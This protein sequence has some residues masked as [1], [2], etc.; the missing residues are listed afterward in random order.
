MSVGASRGYVRYVQEKTAAAATSA[1]STAIQPLVE[2]QDMTEAAIIE[3]HGNSEAAIMQ[4]PLAA[5]A[6]MQTRQ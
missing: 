5:L 2:S 3:S 6:A 1:V 4:L